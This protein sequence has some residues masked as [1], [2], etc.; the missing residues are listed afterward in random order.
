MHKKFLKNISLILFL[1]LLIKPIW[2]FWFDRVVQNQVGVSDYG[3]YFA[4]LNFSFLFNILL[5]FGIINFNNINIAQNNHLL[6]KHLSSIIVLK[7]ILGIIYLIITF[8]CAIFIKYSFDHLLFLV[9]L[10]FQQF[11]ISFIM[12]L[13]SNLSGLHLFKIDSFISVLDRLIM[14]PVCAVFLWGNLPIKFTIGIYAAIITFGYLVTAV[15]A[16]IIVFKKAKSK[17][18]K[19]KWNFP[20]SLMIIRH[21]FPFAIL[22][23]L[24]TFYNRI[25]T[26]MLERMLPNGAEQ[27][28]VYASA[29]RLLDGTN[30]IAFLFAG[31][32]LPIYARMLKFKDNVEDMVKLSYTLLIVPALIIAIGS[33]FYNNEIMI[34]LYPKQKFELTEIYNIRIHQSAVIFSL[35]MGCF[36][37]IST[38]YIFS[39]LL[40]A[41]KNLKQLN[42]IAGCGMVVNI[43]LNI[44]LIPRYQAIGSAFASITTQFLVAATQV[45]YVQKIFKF[46]VNYKLLG[47]LLLFIA[48][49]LYINYISKNYLHFKWVVNFLIMV[50]SSVIWAFAIRIISIRAIYNILKY[51]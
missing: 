36:V 17:F 49:I 29:Y 12:Y 38:M 47:L 3:F 28:G 9:L 1:N 22:V 4:V 21:S 20:F 45:F 27:S 19:L 44:Y 31:M 46:K 8:I 2:I 14:I 51:G 25:D 23:L 6:R 26:V 10:A 42:I 34:L 16:M 30:M 24:M 48:G 13:R 11:L 32:L 33:F 37:C 7:F 18:M 40:T 41:N 43:A 15:I 5:D 39:T 50:I 35:L